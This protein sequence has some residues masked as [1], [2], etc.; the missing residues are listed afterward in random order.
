MYFCQGMEDSPS[1][2]RLQ[3]KHLQQCFEW[4]AEIFKEHDWELRAQ[5]ALWVTSSSIVLSID[6]SISLYMQRSCEAVNT[7][8]L[9][10]VPTYGRPP[11]FSED[12]HEKLSVLSQIIY[13]ENFLFLTHGRAEPTMTQRIEKEFRYQLPVRLNYP[14]S[15]MP[16]S[17]R[18]LI[19]SLS[20]AFQNLPFD[21]AYEDGFTSQGYGNHTRS[22]SE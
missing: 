16:Q 17:Q 14:L 8:G 9:Q 7:G 19:A 20:G 6:H 22:L 2:V 3:A 18:A 15:C 13:F 10:F 5:V 4:L 1:M 11:E 21:Y 12:L